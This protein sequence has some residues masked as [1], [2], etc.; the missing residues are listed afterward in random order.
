MT[1]TRA[2]CSHGEC[3][4]PV[5]ALGLCSNHHRQWHYAQKPAYKCW[6]AMLQRCYNGNDKKYAE[7]GG[8]GITVCERWRHTYDTF[9]ADMGPKPSPTHS[10]DR[11]DNDGNYEPG[12]CRWATKQQQTLNRRVFRNRSGFR[13]V[14]PSA[15]GKQW[16]SNLN[17]LA[18]GHL[19]LGIFR[20]PE[21]AA[22]RYDQF[23]YGLWGED[24][25]LNF[26]YLP[27]MILS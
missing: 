16:V 18:T 6:Q 19:Y 11:I 25:R 17:S 22:W 26:D 14:Y 1:G 4:K 21:E 24:A 23:A 5:L 10:I 27:V 7:Y 20:T 3:G 12:N 9:A 2:S 15:R 8:R 13:G